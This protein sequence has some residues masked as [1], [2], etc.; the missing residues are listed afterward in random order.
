MSYILNRTDVTEW[1]IH[2]VRDRDPDNDFL[3]DEDEYYYLVGGHLEPDA[4]AFAVLKTIVSIGGLKP[5]YSF[6]SGKTT[7]YGGNPAICFT[8]MPIY[9]FAKYT[10]ERGDPKRC[11]PLGICLPKMELYQAGGRPVIYGLSQEEIKVKEDSRYVRVVDESTLTRLEQYR[12]VAFDPTRVPYSL[13]WTHER[14]WRWIANDTHDHKLFMHDYEGVGDF[15]PGLPLFRGK[16]NGGFFSRVGLIVWNDEQGTELGDI[17]L[18]CWD[19]GH[20]NYDEPYSD[21][22]SVFIIV[23]ERVIQEVEA[24]YN[25]RAQRIEDLPASSFF[26]IVRQKASQETIDKVRKAIEGARIASKEAAATFLEKAPKDESG[27]ML[28][29]CGYAWVITYDSPTDI[30]QALLELQMAKPMA[31][32]YYVIEAIGE[33]EVRQGIT[34]NEMAAKTAA[35][36][37]TK[38][39]NQKF[40][41]RSWLD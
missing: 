27:H 35:D 31:G 33:M 11:T 32:E 12:F 21:S 14:E 22:V 1:L 16:S 20:N 18:R 40:Y 4:Q 37:L 38:E 13:D 10:Q 25:L 7:I 8:E 34:Y 17:I 24:R 30:T 23:L 41:F 28:D 15:V 6:R 9:N 5:G 2:F 19:A 39:L 3:G 36:F 26:N 29:A